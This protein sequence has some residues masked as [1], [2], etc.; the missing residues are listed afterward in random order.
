MYSNTRKHSSIVAMQLNLICWLISHVR[1]CKTII[2][3]NKYR[4]E[5]L[6][7]W[8]G[9]SNNVKG[10]LLKNCV[11]YGISLRGTQTGGWDKWIKY[12]TK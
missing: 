3:I 2:I 10:N 4:F 6:S 12:Q 5:V 8:M 1:I 9:H 11:L 7:G